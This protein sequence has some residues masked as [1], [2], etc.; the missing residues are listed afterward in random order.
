M[1]A[2]PVSPSTFIVSDVVAVF[3]N[4]IHRHSSFILA[5]FIDVPRVSAHRSIVNTDDGD[6]AELYCDFDSPSTSKVTWRKN[7]KVIKGEH[8]QVVGVKH[9]II[10]PPKKHHGND[11][12][13]NASI[14]VINKVDKNDLGEYECSVKN[15]IGSESVKILLTLA[16]EA[17]HLDK[18]EQNGDEVTTHW[19]IRSLKPLDEVTLNYQ[20]KG[21]NSFFIDFYSSLL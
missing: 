15:E 21:V 13:K 20:Q 17:P 2:A 19:I 6:N 7:E 1:S 4:S 18:L 16:P 11:D 5:L 8:K 9:L 3:I 14:L 12:Q 10:E